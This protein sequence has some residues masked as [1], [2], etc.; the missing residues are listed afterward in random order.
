M[1]RI[2]VNVR[3]KNLPTEFKALPRDLLRDKNWPVWPFKVQ[4]GILA[5]PQGPTYDMPMN[6]E[7]DPISNARQ[8]VTFIL[9][10]AAALAAYQ[11]GLR[12][13][14]DSPVGV[15]VKNAAYAGM[16]D[17]T[18]ARDTPPNQA[19]PWQAHAGIMPEMDA[20]KALMAA[21]VV[22]SRVSRAWLRGR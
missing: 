17:V 20:I 4:R 22:P 5:Y 7:R 6:A 1:S 8:A 16:E 9:E 10:S 13:V 19:V 12:P 14:G 3:T 21:F 15:A 2:N 11:C 18:Y